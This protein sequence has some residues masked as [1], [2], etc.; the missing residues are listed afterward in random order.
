MT[1]IVACTTTANLITAGLL[2]VWINVNPDSMWGRPPEFEKISSFFGLWHE[3]RRGAHR[4]LHELY[5]EDTYIL[6][7]NTYG[8]SPLDSF[9]HL[10]PSNAPIIDPNTF[11]KKLAL[12]PKR[13]RMGLEGTPATSAG[14]SCDQVSGH[15]R[16]I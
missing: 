14:M 8:A 12:E 3:H 15:M 4:G 10:K 16:R 7:L 1:R 11:D 2:C 6:L 5:W 13:R 9:K